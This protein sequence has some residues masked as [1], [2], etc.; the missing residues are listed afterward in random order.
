M[1]RNGVLAAALLVASP[2]RAETPHPVVQNE[3]VRV[4]RARLAPGEA[5]PMHEHPDRVIVFLTDAKLEVS[6]PDGT[7]RVVERKAGTAESTPPTRHA[8]K[9]LA[10]AP[11]EAVEIELLAD[12]KAAPRGDAAAEDPKHAQLLFET[13]RVRVLRTVVASGDAAPM[14]GHGERVTVILSGGR[15]RTTG[16]DGRAQENDMAGG[17]VAIGAPTRHAA[18]NVGTTPHDAITVE[19]KPAR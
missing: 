17:D 1:L 16:E 2:L 11:F 19:L 14:H 4:F 13:E 18:A 7:S 15:M 6:L 8:I 3:H 12:T 10:D 9:N 5:R